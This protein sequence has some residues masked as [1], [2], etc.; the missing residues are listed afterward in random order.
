MVTEEAR[1][2]ARVSVEERKERVL[3]EFKTGPVERTV[4]EYGEQV[5][6]V[7]VSL[8]LT[9]RLRRDYEMARSEVERDSPCKPG[10]EDETYKEVRAW[11][12]AR[13]RKIHDEIR[14]YVD[15]E[16]ARRKERAAKKKAR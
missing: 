5:S 3:S 4:I 12:N 14:E 16:D 10:T 8:G 7:R 2:A 13:V 15:D 1:A 11:V 6:R 9:L